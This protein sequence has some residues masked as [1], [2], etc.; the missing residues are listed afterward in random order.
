MILLKE[1]LHSE[2]FSYVRGVTTRIMNSHA[3]AGNLIA[4]N[5]HDVTYVAEILMRRSS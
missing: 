3:T 1:R 5:I 4:C 2:D